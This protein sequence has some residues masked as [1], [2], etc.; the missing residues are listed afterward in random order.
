MSP[1]II[2]IIIAV[3]VIIAILLYVFKDKIFKK[4]PG[5]PPMAPPGM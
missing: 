1:T 5:G 4:K 2:G 3:V